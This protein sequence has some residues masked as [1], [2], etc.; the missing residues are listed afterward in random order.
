MSVSFCSVHI[1]LHGH[2]KLLIG[3]KKEK[4]KKKRKEKREKEKK[5][6]EKALMLT[7]G[8]FLKAP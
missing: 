5:R 8:N 1:Y 6:K 7:S 3:K 4:K 2:K